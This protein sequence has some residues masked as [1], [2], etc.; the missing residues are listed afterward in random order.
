MNNVFLYLDWYLGHGYK[1]S[2]GSSYAN[3]ICLNRSKRQQ[4]DLRAYLNR[5]LQTNVLPSRQEESDFENSIKP[6][7]TEYKLFAKSDT[8]LSEILK[9]YKPPVAPAKLDLRAE[10]DKEERKLKIEERSRKVVEYNS[11]LL[12]PQVDVKFPSYP[13][14]R[15]H[16]YLKLFINFIFP[17]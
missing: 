8:E 13:E 6:R 15:P 10:H 4:D 17:C 7:A 3:K 1:I 5:K 16:K 14:G 12:P 11:L 2:P 9:H